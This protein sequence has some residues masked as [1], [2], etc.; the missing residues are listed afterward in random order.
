VL[1][2]AGSAQIT[3]AQTGNANYSAAAPVTRTLVVGK[4]S[5]TIVWSAIPPKIY[6]DDDFYLP[7]ATNTGLSITGS[8]AN[9]NIAI[10]T[11]NK[12]H[13]TGVGTTSVTAI[14]AGNS[15]Y[16]PTSS[17]TLLL[18]VDKA[19]LTITANDAERRFGEP[20]PV[21]TLS[22]SGFKNG[23]TESVL[24]ELPLITCPANINSPAGFY[25]IVLSGGSDNNY[26]YN[27]VNGT[28]EVKILNAL[29]DVRVENISLYPN[30]VRNELFIKS[31]T[32]VEKVTIYDITGVPVIY[33]KSLN[34]QFVDV[35]HL[36]DGV[37]FIRIENYT[38][39][40]VKK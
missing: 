1:H 17:I 33:Q 25:D 40:F 31:V 15:N 29:E 7:V 34:G 26:A 21:F 9:E 35:S 13:I 12:L 2:N 16:L 19:P 37:Y 6:G 18:I 3:A 23:E 30:P 27:L 28:L 22:Y 20:N 11:G 14:Q 10:A 38:G 32:P 36:P 4:A 8:V 39:K 24:D 5:Q